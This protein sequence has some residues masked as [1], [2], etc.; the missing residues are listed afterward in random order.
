MEL[1][2]VP[3]APYKQVWLG[4]K[5]FKKIMCFSTKSDIFHTSNKAFKT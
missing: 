5:K 4:E 2:I 3:Y 1:L